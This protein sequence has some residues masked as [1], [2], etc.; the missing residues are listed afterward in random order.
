[1]KVLIASVPDKPQKLIIVK[2]CVLQRVPSFETGKTTAF[3]PQGIG[4]T[5]G[6]TKALLQNRPGH[7][8]RSEESRSCG[9][10]DPSLRSG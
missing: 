7:S 5:R 1:M 10:S 3:F 8:E 6:L 2:L 9:A 4:D